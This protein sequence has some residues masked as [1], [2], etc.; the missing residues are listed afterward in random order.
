[1]GKNYYTVLGIDKNASQ[2]DIKKAYRKSALKWHPDKNR[3]R[4]EEASEKFR[5]IAEAYDVLSDPEKKRIYDQFGEEGLKGGP[6]PEEAPPFNGPSGPS[7]GGFSYQFNGD[8]NDIFARFFKDSFQRS[9][10][11]AESPF[12]DVG[13]L[14]GGGMFPMG[15]MAMGP[16]GMGMN[17]G[18][19]SSASGEHGRKRPAMFDLHCSLEDLYNG[20]TRKLKVKRT[21]TSLLRADEAVL[22]IAVKPGWKPGTK[23]TFQGEGDEFGNSGQAQDVVFVI[24]EKRHPLYTREGSNLLHHRKIPLVD[25]LTGFKFDLPH[26]EPDKTLRI[27]VNEIVTPTYTKVVKGKGMPS[28]KD[29]AE[30]GD[31]VVTFDIVYPKELPADSKERLKQVLPRF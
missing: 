14:F 28:S 3:E 16:M 21:S 18:G 8:P 5:E 15:G 9:S 10:S 11:F 25:A 22:E 13:G 20:T 19:G 2:E 12:E 1:M 24:R 23:V 6:R 17:M 29:P 26:L 7:H 31:L 27:A 30:K 4:Q